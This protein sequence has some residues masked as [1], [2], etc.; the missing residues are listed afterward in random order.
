MKT[1]TVK[2]S[3][4]KGKDVFAGVKWVDATFEQKEK[5]FAALSRVQKTI[6]QPA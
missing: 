1:T 2:M 5:V 4:V 3:Q 6:K